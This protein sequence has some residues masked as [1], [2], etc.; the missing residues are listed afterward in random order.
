MG[1]EISLNMA[2]NELQR[3]HAMPEYSVPLLDDVY[4]VR[5]ADRV[6]ISQRSSSPAK[7]EASV[8]VLHFLTGTLRQSYSPTGVWISFR[9]LWGGNSFQP[10]FQETTIKPL[11][12]RL[13]EDPDGLVRNLVERFKGR[14]VEGGDVSVELATFPGVCVRVVMWMGDDE[15]PPEAVM[16]FDKGLADALSTE[17]IAV[18]LLIVSQ[19]AI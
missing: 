9:E 7:E 10:A 16:L 5:M 1:Y 19:N 3:L 8:I 15:L 4:T 2:W 6:V 13:K 11:V 14:I 12:E 18:L 17:D